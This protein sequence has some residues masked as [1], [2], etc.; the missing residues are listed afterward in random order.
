MP[1]KQTLYLLLEHKFS[2]SKRDSMNANYS[3]AVLIIQKYLKI[4]NK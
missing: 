1:E 4:Y 3:L 2:E